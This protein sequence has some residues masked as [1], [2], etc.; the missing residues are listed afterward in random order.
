M[1][2]SRGTRKTLMACW[3]PSL[4][5]LEILV[6]VSHSHQVGTYKGSCTHASSGRLQR[7]K[8]RKRRKQVGADTIIVR[9]CLYRVEA[10]LDTREDKAQHILGNLHALWS[11]LHFKMLKCWSVV[12]YLLGPWADKLEINFVLIWISWILIDPYCIQLATPM[13]NSPISTVAKDSRSWWSTSAAPP[14]DAHCV[15]L[16]AESAREPLDVSWSRC[17]LE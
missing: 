14:W 5:A 8:Q 10:P 7:R 17:N 9:W 6:R 2:G 15:G 3:N 13:Q 11:A 4:A 16:W 12:R 1:P